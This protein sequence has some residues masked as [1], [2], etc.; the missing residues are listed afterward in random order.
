MTREQLEEKRVEAA[1][2]LQDMCVYAD[3]DKHKKNPLRF[4]DDY[5][6]EEFDKLHAAHADYQGKIIA[7][8]EFDAQKIPTVDAVPEVRVEADKRNISVDEMSAIVEAKKVALGKFAYGE[9]LTPDEVKM[10]REGV[11]ANVSRGSDGGVLVDD[12]LE[13][14]LITKRKRIVGM[15]QYADVR[16]VTSGNQIKVSNE[17]LQSTIGNVYGQPASEGNLPTDDP[18]YGQTL[19]DTDVFSS[20]RVPLDWDAEVDSP[21]NLVGSIT[22]TIRTRLDRTGMQT[23]YNGSAGIAGN[24]KANNKGLFEDITVEH[25]AASGENDNISWTTIWGAIGKIDPEYQMS[26]GIFMNHA[27]F[28]HVAGWTVSTTDD[29]PLFTPMV[30]NG[31][32]GGQDPNAVGYIRNFP[33]YLN[34]AMPG[35]AAQANAIVIGDPMTYRIYQSQGFTLYRIG[36]TDLTVV[37][38]RADSFLGYQRWGHRLLLPEAWVKIKQAA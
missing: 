24:L 34:Q 4:K 37:S 19:V 31:I 2:K 8:D 23:S 28:N 1:R 12:V 5:N 26:A 36:S 29:R 13:S 9:A 10:M 7:L 15:F 18:D 22:N 14:S 6:K 25:D 32:E 27:T 30:T 33:V 3:D 20:L 17:D 21:I 11:Q 16:N 38:Q 35:L